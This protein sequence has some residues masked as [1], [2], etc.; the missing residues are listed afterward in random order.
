MVALL[1]GVVTFPLLYTGAYMALK[2]TKQMQALSASSATP[3]V[4]KVSCMP[5]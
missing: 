2:V 3:Q 5:V 1:L 4:A